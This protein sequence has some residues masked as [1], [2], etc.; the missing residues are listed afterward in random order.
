MGVRR[1]GASSPMC[2]GETILV[3]TIV[4]VARLPVF[5]TVLRTCDLLARH[6][7]K[8]IFYYFALG[9]M[10]VAMFVVVDFVIGEPNFERKPP[11]PPDEWVPFVLLSF[12]TLIPEIAYF[13]AT[14]RLGATGRAD[15]NHLLGLRWWGRETCVLLRSVLVGLILGLIAAPAIFVAGFLFGAIRGTAA[16]Q[17]PAEFLY[18]MYLIGIPLLYLFGRL[19]LYCCSPALGERLG[20]GQSWQLTRGNGWRLFF[21]LLFL[22]GPFAFIMFVIDTTMNLKGTLSYGIVAGVVTILW[23]MV[24]G[25]GAAV[26]YRAFVPRVTEAEQGVAVMAR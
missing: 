18:L 12:A 10:I 20:F 19:S 22:H 15:G 17:P 13:V 6:F 21:V 9:L 2:Q 7:I 26:I 24:S 25:F 8:A 1:F 14:M 3:T 4:S 16:E 23:V 11:P 5:E